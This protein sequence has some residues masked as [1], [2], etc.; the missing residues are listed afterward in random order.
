MLG[1]ARCC[2]CCVA[3]SASTAWRGFGLGFG[4]G[5]RFGFRFGFGLGQWSA[6]HVGHEGLQPTEQRRHRLAT[7]GGDAEHALVARRLGEGA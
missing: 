4:F 3:D 5:F 2:W 7:G 1:L 6:A